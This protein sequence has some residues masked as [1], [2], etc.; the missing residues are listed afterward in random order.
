MSGVRLPDGFRHLERFA[1]WCVPHEK[2]RI[3]RRVTVPFEEIRSFYDAMLPEVTGIVGYLRTRPVDQ[4]TPEDENLLFLVQSLIEISGAVEVYG[5]NRITD[6]A[7]P[8]LLS[9]TYEVVGV[10][11]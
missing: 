11:F 4:A 1:D 5:E 9:P 3:E 7:D 8:R 6:G 2:D 10:R